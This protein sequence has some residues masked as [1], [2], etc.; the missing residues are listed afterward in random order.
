[1]KLKIYCTVIEY[2]DPGIFPLLTKR[3]VLFGHALSMNQLQMENFFSVDFILW[4][5]IIPT[6]VM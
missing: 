6:S 5:A 4:S 3:I 1:M 2:D